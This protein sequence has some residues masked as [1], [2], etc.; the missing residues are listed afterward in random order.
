[1]TLACGGHPPPLVRR[2][3]GRVEALRD[4]GPL[5]GVFPSATYPELSVE[6]A[7]EDTLLLYTDGLIERN[8]RL[9]GDAALRALLGS[10]AFADVDGL[11]AQLE[12]RALGT[13]PERLPDDTAVLAIQVVARTPGGADANGAGSPVL[14]QALAQ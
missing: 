13:P 2:G 4:H 12:V 9:P 14:V 3:S 11:I 7:P 6:L 1:V 10:L 8:P 5:L